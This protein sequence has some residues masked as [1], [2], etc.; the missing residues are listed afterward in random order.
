VNI[1]DFSVSTMVLVS[2]RMAIFVAMG[3]S[4]W[5]GCRFGGLRRGFFAAAEWN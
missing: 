1:V 4:G 3:K 2:F 5:L